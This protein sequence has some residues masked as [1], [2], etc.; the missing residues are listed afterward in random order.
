VLVAQRTPAFVAGEA[1]L[2][3]RIRL[4]AF[5]RRA[6]LVNAARACSPL[7]SEVVSGRLIRSRRS[8]S[9]MAQPI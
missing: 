2:A 9:V 6:F 7:M 8:L 1:G 3:L 5:A 4:G